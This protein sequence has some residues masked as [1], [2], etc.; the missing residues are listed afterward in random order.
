MT[1][2]LEYNERNW[3]VLLL[4]MIIGNSIW[5]IISCSLTVTFPAFKSYRFFLILSVNFAMLQMKTSPLVLACLYLFFLF[6][7]IFSICFLRDASPPNLTLFARYIYFHYSS[8]YIHFFSSLIRYLNNLI[9]NLHLLFYRWKKKK[10]SKN[11]SFCCNISFQCTLSNWTYPLFKIWITKHDNFQRLKC[12]SRFTW[13]TLDL[14]I[15]LIEVPFIILD[16]MIFFIF[17][18]VRIYYIRSEQ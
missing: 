10:Y 2:R 5:I 14:F 8:K 18:Y 17:Y 12:F 6:L 9:L 15:Q 16:F 1:N 11:Y 3:F 4:V 13:D 7:F